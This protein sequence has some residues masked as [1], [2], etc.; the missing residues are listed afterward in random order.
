MY[1]LRIFFHIEFIYESLYVYSIVSDLDNDG[2][3]SS[4]KDDSTYEE[5]KT[6][7]ERPRA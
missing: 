2:C 3:N 7:Q 1:R 5:D 6:V 4:K